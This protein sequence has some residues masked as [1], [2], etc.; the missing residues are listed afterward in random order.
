MFTRS[1]L[2][3]FFRL[4][5][6][7]N[8]CVFLALSFIIYCYHV[9]CVIL[10]HTHT[11]T[12]TLGEKGEGRDKERTILW[13]TMIFFLFE[14]ESWLNLFLWVFFWWFELM[15]GTRTRETM[16][17]GRKAR[18]GIRERKFNWNQNLTTQTHTFT[19]TRIQTLI[20][21]EKDM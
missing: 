20:K 12:H 6:A 8:H 14:F 21:R 2:S 13:R 18:S 10:L 16:R 5:P 19:L 3:H 4:L 15:R 1:P 7:C 9:T 11:D 17:N